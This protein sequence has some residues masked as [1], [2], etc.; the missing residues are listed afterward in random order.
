MDLH[1]TTGRRGLG[2]ALACTTMLMWGT[3]PI[4]LKGLLARLDPLTI[5]WVRFLVSGVALFAVLGSR[6]TL[7]RPSAWS[8]SQ[9]LLLAAAT[10]FLG[11][12]YW[13]YIAALDRST[14]IDAQVLI[15]LA[16]LLLALGGVFVFGEYFTRLQWGAFG[17][18][19]GGLGLFFAGQLGAL[20]TG[21]SRYLGAV[22]LMVF[23]ALT[24]AIYGLAQKQLLH[25]LRSQSVMLVIYLG[26][27]V[28][29]SPLSAPGA[30]PGLDGVGW[31]LLLYAAAN[32]LVAY[33]TF[34]ESLQHW[35]ASRVSAV[36]ALTPLATL[37]FGRLA[38]SLWPGLEA[39][40]PLAWS[41][42][43]GAGL[44]VTGSLGMALGGRDGPAA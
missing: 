6:G 12:N 30:L 44:V 19:I 21:L 17:V 38:D 10:A 9:W 27:A 26:C 36:L 8:R 28:I 22:A 29:F 43:L 41:S 33:G 34:S 5:T 16:P 2:F 20:V 13:G 31:G 1:R 15:Q 35:E 7:P 4:A 37:C 24:W 23:A 40:G 14:A 18:L 3:L 39:T 42:L 32:T 11:A 25:G